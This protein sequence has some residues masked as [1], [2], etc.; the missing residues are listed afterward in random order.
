[1]P[2][3][4]RESACLCLPLR[5]L[6]QLE[7]FVLFLGLNCRKLVLY[8]THPFFF[9][10]SHTRNCLDLVRFISGLTTTTESSSRGLEN[11]ID[12]AVIKG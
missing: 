3:Q 11:S 6:W 1:M 12:D 7:E 5:G 8:D 2:L 10:L 9:T 4:R